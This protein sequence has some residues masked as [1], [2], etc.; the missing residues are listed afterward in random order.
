M[1][2]KNRKAPREALTTNYPS[3]YNVLYGY[4]LI[5]VTYS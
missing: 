2:T 5:L 1:T 4:A 3:Q